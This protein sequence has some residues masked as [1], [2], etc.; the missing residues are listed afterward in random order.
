MCDVVTDSMIPKLIIKILPLLFF[1]ILGITLGPIKSSSTHAIAMTL[2]ERTVGSRPMNPV[3]IDHLWLMTM[4]AA[5][6]SRLILQACS[7][8]GGGV[9]QLIHTGEPI[10][11][12]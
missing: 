11:R 1:D 3:G 2:P 10:T 9:A 8:T 6:D 7:F 5:T 12:D 4:T